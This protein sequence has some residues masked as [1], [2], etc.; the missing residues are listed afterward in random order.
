[1]ALDLEAYHKDIEDER[2]QDEE[3]AAQ[4][5]NQ[6]AWD[7]KPFYSKAATII[8]EDVGAIADAAGDRLGKIRDA[9]SAYHDAQVASRDKYGIYIPTPEV[10]EAGDNLRGVVLE[11]VTHP[12][13]SFVGGY[14]NQKADEG[15]TIAQDVRQSETFVHYFMTPEDKL[16]KAKEIED[17]TGISADA[18]I[19]DDVAYKQALNVYDYK[20]AKAAVMPE[21]QAMEAVWQEFPELRNV[22]LT[23]PTEAALALHDMDSVRQ[24][25]GI[26]ETFNHFIALGNKELEYN[27]LQYKIMTNRADDNDR[28]RA[29]DL[30][31][32]IAEDKKAAPSF[33]DDPLSAIVGGMASSGPEM[34]QSIREGVRDGLITAEAAALAGAALGTGIEP[35]GGTLVGGAVGAAGGFV[36]GTAR[37]VITRATMGQLARAGLGAGMRVGIFEGMRRPET[38]SRF[39]EYGN[40]KDTDG[41]PLLTDNDRRFYS[42]LGGAANAGIEMVGLGI[43]TKPL[44]RGAVNFLTKG[45]TDKYAVDAIKG[46][47]DAAK[48][49]VAKRESVAAFAKAQVKDTLK[50]AATESAEEGAQ[51]IADD[52]IHNRIVDASDGRAADKA[53]SIGDIAANALVASVEAIP[54]GLGFGMASSLGGG[55]LGSVRHARRL[56]SEKAKEELAAQKTMTGTVMLNRLQQVASSAKLKETAPDVQQ[57][58]I[59]TQ[60]QGSGFE[61]AYIDTAMAVKKEN[62]LADLKE[63][64][65]TAGIREEE[66]QKTIESGGHLFVPA[67]KYAQSAASPQLLE[68]VSFTPETDSIARMKE[69]AKML[70]D[71]LETA[72]KRA[73]HARADIVKSIA[74]EYFPEARENLDEQE[75]A[76]LYSE[77]DMAKAVIAQNTE[78]PAE[79]WRSLYN[80]FT[81]ARDEILQPAMDALSKGMKQGVDILPLGEDGRGI[82]VSNNAPWYQEYYK[83]HGKAPNQAQ[84]RDLAYLLTVGDASA[85]NVEGW[86]PTTREAAEAMDAARGELDE[87]NGHIQ[88]LEN[89]KERMMKVD[90][91]EVKGSAGLS[92]EGYK[93]Y[94]QIMETL[95]KIGGEQKE[96]KQTKVARMNAML[97]AH[98]ADIFAAAMRTQEGK[99]EY[100]ALDYFRDRFA[101]RYGGTDMRDGFAQALNAGVNLDEQVPI[102]DITAALPQ[103]KMSNKD[104]LN[105]LRGLAQHGKTITSTDGKAVFGID[106]HVRHITFSS[107]KGLSDDESKV[108][109]ASIR[110]LDDLLKHAVLVESVPNRKTSKKPAAIAYHRFYVP[111][112]LNGKIATI[113]I[114][115]EERGDV[116]TFSPTNVHLYD[117]I[118]EKRNSRPPQGI[119]PFGGSTRASDTISIRDMLTGV[120]DADGNVYAQSATDVPSSEKE[121]VRKQYEGT[122]QWMKAPNGEATKLTEDQWV[123]VR[124]PAF[125]AWFGDWENAPKN[126][127]KVV[128][129]NGEPLVV[130]HATREVFDTFKPSES[131]WYGSGVYLTSDP[132][133]TSYS[134]TEPDWHLMPLFAYI[135]NPLFAG[136]RV[137]QEEI[138]AVKKEV[139]DVYRSFK[140]D[141]EN[142]AAGSVFSHLEGEEK[143]AAVIDFLV[144]SL[145]FF[146][147]EAG[148]TTRQQL[149]NLMKDAYERAGA[150]YDSPHDGVIVP[151]NHGGTWFV[152][153]E[154]HQVKSATKNNGA[155]DYGDANIYHQSAW[156]GSPHDFVEF[157]LSAIGTGEGAQ[158]HGWGL[159]FAQNREV[160]EW[161]K[162]VLGEVQRA[163]IHAGDKTY[164]MHPDGYRIERNSGDALQEGSPIEIALSAFEDSDANVENAIRETTDYLE[165]ME[166]IK[167]SAARERNKNLIREALRILQEEADA[168]KLEKKKSSLFKVEIPDDDVLLDE[169]KSIADQH[170]NVRELLANIVKEDGGRLL[171]YLGYE[172]HN[173]RYAEVMQEYGRLE[174]LIAFGKRV[175]DGMFV[176]KFL[177]AAGHTNEEVDIFRR[178]HAKA[179]TE[180][181]RLIKEYSKSKKELEQKIAGFAKAFFKDENILKNI[182]G[183]NFYDAVAHVH[184][185]QE[186]AS[187]YLNIHGIKGITYDGQ[188]DGRCFVIFD[189]QAIQIIEKFNQMLRQE[190][191]GEISKEDG[192]RIITLFESAD[193]STFMHEMGHMFLMDLDELAKMDEASA[194]ELETVNAWAEWHE[195]AA[196]EYKDTDFADEFRDH[197]NAILAAKKSGDAVAEKA[198]MERWRQERFARGFEMYLSEGKA[199]SAAMRSVFRRFK[200]FLRKIYNLAKNAGAMPSAKVQAVMARMIATENEIAEAKLDERFRPIEKLLGKESV[201]S[202]LGE[203]EAELYKRWTQEAQEEAE[204]ILRK[205]VM[206]DLKKEAREEFNQKVEAERERKRAEL[207]NDPVYL[208]EY[209]M[210]QGGSTD[211]V[212]NWFPSYAAYKKARGKRKTLEN[213]LKDY[214]TEYARNLDEQIMQAHLS[215]ENVARAMQTPKA[216]HRR[217]AIESAALRRKERLMRLLGGNAPEEVKKKAVA[218][219]KKAESPTRRG[220]K[221]EVRKEYERSAH[222]HERFMRE[223]ARAYLRE[224]EISESCNPRFFRRNERKHARAMD[225]AAAA[226]K[227]SDVL[228]L[229]EQQA[230]AAACAYEAERNE[231]RL[232]K[233][234]EGVKRKLNARTVRLAADERYWLNHIGYLLGLKANDEEKPVKCAKLS[235]LFARY[236][237]NIDID[238]CDP[239]DLL[240]V[241]TEGKKRYQEMQLDDFADIVN[242]LGILYNVGR[243]R[244]EM[245]TKSMQGKTTDDVLGEIFAD[246]TALKP[247][248][249]VEN[250]VS[251]DTG[252]IGYGELLAKTPF[253]GKVLAKYGQEG[254]LLLTKPELIMRLIGEK[255]HRYLYGT[256]ERAQMKESEILGEKKEELEKIFSVYTRKERMK[257]KDRNIDAHGDML[258]K[259]NVLCLAMNWGTFTNRKR[260]LDGVGQKFD[261]IRTLHEN[262]TEKDWKVVQEVWNLLDTFWEESA[263]T[264]ERL[265]GAHIGKVPA[266]EFTIKT[267]DGKE[268]TLKGGYYPLRYNAEKSSNVQDKTAEEAAKGTMTGAQVFGTK[269]GHTKARVEGDV[270]LPVLLEFSVLQEHVY[271]AAHNIAFR[272]AA[273]D[274]Y[275]IINDKAFEAYVSSNYGRPVYKYLKQWAVDVWAIPADG[276]DLAGSA[277]SRALAAFRRNSTMAIMGWRVWPVVE[278]VSNIAP[279][280]DKLGARRALQAVMA[281]ALHPKTLLAMSK[282]SIFM[283]DRINNM[284]RDVRRDSHTFD[285]TYKPLEFLRDNAYR[286]L[287]FTDL[288]LSVPTWNSAY[289]EA[290]PKA[291]A[292]INEE[293][294]ANKRTYQEA[295]NRVHELRAEIYDLRREMEEKVDPSLQERIRAKEKEFA[296]AGIAL[297]RAGELPIYDEAERIREAEMRAVQA[298]DAAVRDTFGS[299]Q[300]KDLAA[301]QRSRNEAVKMFTSFYSFFNTQFNAV[302]ESYYGGK[303]NADGYRHIRVWMPFARSMLYRI[304]LVGLIGGLG[305]AALGLEGDDDR[306]KYRN[307]VDPKTGKTTK[308]EVPWE[309]RW[310]N[311]IGKNTVSTATGMIPLVRDLIGMVTDAFFDGTARGRNFEVGSV[312][313]RGGKQAVATWNLI[314][315]KGE[316]DLKREAEEAK[317][318]ERVN[319]MT[320]KQRE[321]YEEGKKYKKPKKEVGYV[322]IAKSAA[323]TVSTFTASRHGVTNTLSDGVFSAVQFA[324]DMMETDNYYDPRVTNVMRA[325]IFDKKLREKEVPKKPEPPKKQRRTRGRKERTND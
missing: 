233:L 194:K 114:V 216:Y 19:N 309:E 23:N 261:V 105:F 49:D 281:F 201:E 9:Y 79:G 183:E 164:A 288:A 55:S 157:L 5:A 20:R 215:D 220:T 48:Y 76:R 316:D 191:R 305:K 102:V 94:R 248:G 301:I 210:R 308:V 125:K 243:R 97:F 119:S 133:D 65:K 45:G 115:G 59:R 46:V 81:A 322:D 15:S 212:M 266:H 66:L 141:E 213:E 121:A 50:I 40:M 176:T 93:L 180:K 291:I 244:N 185:S 187:R 60:V 75:K 73:V 204:D 72:Q 202:L 92:P 124:T 267:A 83:Q 250:P 211:V 88:T 22:S 324:V 235:E 207:E 95:E 262:M 2:R 152:A 32:M 151:G 86:I 200:A 256:Y 71:A 111:V 38:G 122:A 193:E 107:R 208:A 163:I 116:I 279:V 260:V 178:D 172:E 206:N 255:A 96:D 298:G 6:T 221:Q 17:T 36:V 132:N 26:V 140:Y 300:T 112:S 257:W 82:R 150:F 223:E 189:D 136:E 80:D 1:M 217:L 306:D 245:L 242:A 8:S 177:R 61:N 182:T 169:Q 7:A 294:E 27:N 139:A 154:R 289:N 313:S 315:K 253:V 10:Q 285:P 149:E 218:E 110:S 99:E 307:V 269:R 304:I 184:E 24:T 310:M 230:F 134:M 159:Y 303:Y 251:E 188:R 265:N 299:G 113:R 241:I 227:W 283:A 320:R 67:E 274:V 323:Q 21:D 276:T 77:R 106:K 12:I 205:Q 290:F 165:K 297:E 4:E 173:K 278:N 43:A 174:S 238:A 254:S 155:Y 156:H 118:V 179:V 70:S 148:K 186:E 234:V 282:K 168:W 166:R 167:D 101:L 74:D 63:V 129:E 170:K 162:A 62:G 198:A 120:K 34:L 128:D 259:E 273:R 280:V 51:S 146:E 13:K 249:I 270:V 138:D 321:K 232:N 100:T 231:A 108:R 236:K 98:H 89:I 226:G 229:K 325:V 195:G 18:F 68:S 284:E 252:G 246:D 42:V 44:S 56:F 203:T 33:F 295:Q 263:R 196:E 35:L 130:Y 64:A 153:R 127:S 190:V 3:R 85:P 271:N 292:Q 312:L 123:A 197:E 31:R 318:R 137:S 160:S 277:V 91:F 293:N 175:G 53:Y 224:R 171:K 296:E 16:K 147:V 209:A 264:E 317:E 286:A 109:Q 319:K 219:A 142:K 52:L 275:R 69:N 28:E 47:V 78:S 11:P 14:I 247:S 192:K 145:T 143:R 84:L 158:T 126:A 268:V 258:S 161:Y 117:V 228:A 90:S 237:D 239:S 199:P 41:N 30:E 302:L 314:M 39:A 103:K 25:H 37:S 222:E 29:A 87:L 131:G 287:S 181:E 311:V 272:I 54:A 104:V 57:K 214:I 58:I 240:D 135:Y 225:K 144:E